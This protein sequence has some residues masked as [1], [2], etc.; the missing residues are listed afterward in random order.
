MG[1]Y[2]AFIKKYIKQSD[3]IV[4][5]NL[6]HDLFVELTEYKEGEKLNLMNDFHKLCDNI[7]ISTNFVSLRSNLESDPNKFKFVGSVPYQL[8]LYNY[9][10]KE[11]YQWLYNLDVKSDTFS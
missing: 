9:S 10:S 1:D 2:K 11:Q 7:G 3:Y 6:I 5:H 4:K 8:E